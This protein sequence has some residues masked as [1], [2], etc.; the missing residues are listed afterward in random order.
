MSKERAARIANSPGASR[1]GGKKSGSGGNT[2]PVA[3]TAQEEG[4]WPQGPVAPARRSR[5]GGRI[6]EA[7]LCAFR[8]RSIVRSTSC[9]TLGWPRKRASPTR[10]S[11]ITFTPG[12][13]GRGRVR[14]S[15]AYWVA[16]LPPAGAPRD[17]HGRHLSYDPHPPRDRGPGSRHGSLDAAWPVCLGVGTGENLN[18][19]VLGD[20]WPPP[21]MRLEML[22]EAVELMRELWT[23]ELTTRRGRHYCVERAR[24]YTLPDEQIP[25]MVAAGAPEAA[26]LAGRVGDGFIGTAPERQLLAEF[27]RAGG[28]GK[29]RFGQVTVCYAES[30]DKARRTATGD[31]AQC[32]SQGN[33]PAGARDT[34]GLRSSRGDGD[35]GG[36]GQA[37]RLR[38]RSRTACRDDRAVRAGWVRPRLRAPDSA[39]SRR[40]FSSSTRERSCRAAHRSQRP[41]SER[42]RQPGDPPVAGRPGRAGRGRRAQTRVAVTYMIFDLLR[43]DGEDV[44]TRPYRDRR[45]LVEALELNGPSWVTPPGSMTEG[46]YGQ[47]CAGTVGSKVWWRSLDRGRYRTGDRGWV[48][49]KNSA[50]WRRASEVEGS[51]GKSRRRRRT[52]VA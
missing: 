3:P 42:S 29:P 41:D 15:G 20:R 25:V 8:A 4:C 40:S 26:R 13:T 34:V 48:K 43:I 30:E 16:S 23:G 18:E 6:C 12:S 27:D 19:H 33:A 7:G 9:A 14:S 31:L 50:Y 21:D 47:R 39:P 37:C 32:G 45:D 5:N 17:W 49:V 46:H 44:T 11:G 24:I 2:S 52:A 28:A 1:R 22:E 36:H 35:R 38:P 51:A 10:S